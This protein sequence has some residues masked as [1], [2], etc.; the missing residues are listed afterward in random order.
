MFFYSS[1]NNK[2]FGNLVEGNKVGVKIWAGSFRNEV[3]GNRF[4]INIIP[5]TA[6]QTTFGALEPGC[7]VNLEVDIIARYLERLMSGK[8]DS[9]SSAG[10][11]LDKLVS[12]GF[13][14]NGN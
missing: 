14:G 5:H 6:E 13:A 9:A 8:Q 12:A 10:V 11:T 7:K 1:T 3:E 2:I 4:G